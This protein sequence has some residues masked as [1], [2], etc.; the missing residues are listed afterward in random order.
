MFSAPDL[1]I[2]AAQAL[3]FL[4]FAFPICLWVIYSDLSKMLI[5]NKAVLALAA[6]FL[7]IGLIMLPFPV[8][9]WRVVTMI[10]VLVAGIAINAA[11]ILGAGDA[12]FIAAAAPFVD[13]GDLGLVLIIFSVN[14]VAA[15]AT[16]R[17]VKRSPLRALAPGW[18][19]WS[20]SKKFPLG[21]ALG[22]TMII[23]LGLGA[24][25]GG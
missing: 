20:R 4:L 17:L 19:S 5:R 13:P 25:Y 2:T 24:I 11:G 1:H 14:A 21:F 18:E 7:V 23:Y 6:V 8:Y 22:S 10:L 3:W 12:K 9:I 15:Y 16:H